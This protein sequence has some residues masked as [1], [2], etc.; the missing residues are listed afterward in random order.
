MSI[1]RRNFLS[2]KKK[3]DST[4]F[5]ARGSRQAFSRVFESD[6]ASADALEKAFEARTAAYGAVGDKPLVRAT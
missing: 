1:L 5:T 3:L 2:A 4:P 6:D